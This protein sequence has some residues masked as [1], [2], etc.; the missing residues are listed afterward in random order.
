MFL[1]SK[2]RSSWQEFIGVLISDVPDKQ[3]NLTT[4]FFS[5]ESWEPSITDL[6][7]AGIRHFRELRHGAREMKERA[8]KQP[9]AWSSQPFVWTHF[10]NVPLGL[11]EQTTSTKKMY[12]LCEPFLRVPSSTT[13]STTTKHLLLRNVWKTAAN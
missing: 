1:L 13:G 4:N 2:S 12:H 7:R 3:T 9:E 5:N 6:T 10:T 11:V 8:G